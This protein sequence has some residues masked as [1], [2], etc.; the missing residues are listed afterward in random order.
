MSEEGDKLVGKLGFSPQILS[1]MLGKAAGR[2][3]DANCRAITEQTAI[4]INF[5]LKKKGRSNKVHMLKSS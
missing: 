4:F 3:S 1:K 5:P 2:A